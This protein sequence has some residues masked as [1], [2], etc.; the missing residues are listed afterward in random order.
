M[1]YRGIILLRILAY[2][3]GLKLLVITQTHQS[4]IKSI[5]LMNLYYR[6]KVSIKAHQDIL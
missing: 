6:R 3:Y 5:I 4:I 1:I 2:K